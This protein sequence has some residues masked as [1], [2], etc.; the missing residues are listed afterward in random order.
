MTSRTIQL[1]DAITLAMQA[2][3]DQLDLGLQPYL[4]HP[5]RVA[6]AMGTDHDAMI[7][8]LLHDVVEDSDIGR[9]RSQAEFSYTAITDRGLDYRPPGHNL[10]RQ[11]VYAFR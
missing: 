2:H 6:G 5:L 4:A 10:T 3:Q 11:E 9:S 7:I 1:A 8:A